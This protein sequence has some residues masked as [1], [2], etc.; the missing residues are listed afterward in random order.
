MS[1]LADIDR[2][3]DLSV[4]RQR[5]GERNLQS[6][7]QR[8]VQVQRE[9]CALDEH[10]ASLRALLGSHRAENCVL[11]HWQL[12]ETLRRQAVIR[13]QIQLLVL[14]RGPLHEQRTQMDQDVHRWQ[15]KML[16]LRRKHAKYVGLRQRL[17]REH[18]LER[19]RRDEG[20]IEDLIGMN[21]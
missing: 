17:G 6:A 14:E 16:V 2:L 4:W 9:L 7:R 15:R 12:L 20:E 18:R 3:L 1:S 5:Q 10:E 19:L 11:D 21:G 8:L 13:R